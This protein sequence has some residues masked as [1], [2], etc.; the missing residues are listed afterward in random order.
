MCNI[1]KILNNTIE[2]LIFLHFISIINTCHTCI[3]TF[4]VKI[5]KYFYNLISDTGYESIIKVFGNIFKCHTCIC[6]KDRK[7]KAVFFV[8]CAFS[9]NSPVYCIQNFICDYFISNLHVIFWSVYVPF[10]K[11]S[12]T[13]IKIGLQ[14]VFVIVQIMITDQHG[15]VLDMIDYITTLPR[16]LNLQIGQ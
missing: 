7:F 9:S 1:V 14:H 2:I 10:A 3:D 5:I 15:S 11:I 12:L 16:F 4:C 6:K 13:Q 8:Q